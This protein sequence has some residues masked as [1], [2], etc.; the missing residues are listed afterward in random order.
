MK[1][2]LLAKKRRREDLNLAVCWTVS[3]TVP[4]C[5]TSTNI[6]SM[7]NILYLQCIKWLQFCTVKVRYLGCT[8]GR[9][10][11]RQASQNLELFAKILPSNENNTAAGMAWPGILCQQRRQIFSTGEVLFSFVM[12]AWQGRSIWFRDYE[13]STKSHLSQKLRV[14]R[15]ASIWKCCRPLCKGEP[16]GKGTNAAKNHLQKKLKHNI[17]KMEN[18]LDLKETDHFIKMRRG[19]FK[20]LRKRWGQNGKGWE[21]RKWHK[22]FAYFHHTKTWNP[23]PHWLFAFP[24]EIYGEGGA[25]REK[26]GANRTLC[27]KFGLTCKT[28]VLIF[29]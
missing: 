7:C 6:I 13:S 21:K 26:G 19:M 12:P 9:F 28:L 23:L 3:V 11:L 22:L 17:I 4:L 16:W 27:N 20:Y 15:L 10:L 24:A 29:S 14:A 18:S 25:E 5:W 2:H 1:S 8:R